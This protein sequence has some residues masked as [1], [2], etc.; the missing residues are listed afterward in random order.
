AG[1]R[2]EPARGP[3]VPL[4]GARAAAVRAPSV[5]EGLSINPGSRIVA[6]AAADGGPDVEIAVMALDLRELLDA[7][8]R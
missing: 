3:A 7:L 1:P 8:P 4:A 5:R 6:C 2:W